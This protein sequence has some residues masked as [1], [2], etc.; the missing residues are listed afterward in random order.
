MAAT[1]ANQ[2]RSPTIYPDRGPHVARDLGGAAFLC[3]LRRALGHRAEGAHAVSPR[4][5]GADR[6]HRVVPGDRL[7]GSRRLPGVEAAGGARHDRPPLRGRQ[8]PEEQLL[9]QR[10]RPVVMQLTPAYIA[11]RTAQKTVR[12]RTGFR[13]IPCAPVQGFLYACTGFCLETLY[14]R[15]SRPAPPSIEKKETL[16][17]DNCVRLLA[18]KWTD[19]AE[20]SLKNTCQSHGDVVTKDRR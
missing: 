18:A 16:L 4:R 7:Q 11:M 8:A 13:H 12:A 5:P 17:K 14:G 2:D 10:P 20:G 19:D 1:Q 9:G 15:S 6:D 3:R